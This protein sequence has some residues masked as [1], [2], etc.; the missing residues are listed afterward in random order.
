M[1][2]MKIRSFGARPT[3]LIDPEAAAVP[4]SLVVG[5]IL[6]L[7]VFESSSLIRSAQRFPESI[8]A[9]TK[10]FRE[11]IFVLT[12]PTGGPIEV[13]SMVGTALIAVSTVGLSSS[14]KKDAG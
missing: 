5:F 9:F 11:C 12:N 3:I 4:T 6:S 1:F 14:L 2:S 8:R 10:I 13:A 7:R